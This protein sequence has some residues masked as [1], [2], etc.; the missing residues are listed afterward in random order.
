MTVELFHTIIESLALGPG[1]VMRRDETAK[2]HKVVWPGEADWF[3]TGDWLDDAVVTTVPF[4][5]IV[6]IVAIVAARPST[7]AFSRMIR[8][9]CK[10]GLVPVV[11]CPFPDMEEILKKWGWEHS[12]EGDGFDSVDCWTPPASF[13]AER[14][15]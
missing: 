14:S 6:R 12:T 11:V 7:G 13:I 2:G 15:L 8:G 10:S 1:N 9:I 5:P 4:S 3:V